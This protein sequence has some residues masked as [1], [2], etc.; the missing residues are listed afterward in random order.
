MLRE[1]SFYLGLPWTS[2]F[3]L[4]VEP[5]RFWSIISY[6]FQFCICQIL[7]SHI[8]GNHQLYISFSS[9]LIS[10]LRRSRQTDVAGLQGTLNQ[11][12]SL[13]RSTKTAVAGERSNSYLIKPTKAF[14]KATVAGSTEQQNLFF[15]SSTLSKS[16]QTLNSLSQ[17]CFQF[18]FICY[19]EILLRIEHT[20]AFIKK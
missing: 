10:N 3:N 7:V 20:A 11:Q 6:V 14:A 9:Y 1:K 16:S 15:T 17:N 2:I 5:K 18:K 13:R 4:W 19:Q 12:F 8:C